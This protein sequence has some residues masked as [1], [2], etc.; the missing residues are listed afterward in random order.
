MFV[1]NKENTKCVTMESMEIQKFYPRHHQAVLDSIYSEERAFYGRYFWDNYDKVME[2][3]RKKQEDY[4]TQNSVSKEA[5]ICING[6]VF[7]FYNNADAA[8]DIYNGIIQAVKEC[9]PIFCLHEF[10]YIEET[11]N[12]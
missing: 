10:D 4:I 5:N 12:S 1:T 7:G 8:Q 6:E 3:I 11:Y 9:K 2:H